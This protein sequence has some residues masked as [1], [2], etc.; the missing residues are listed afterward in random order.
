MDTSIYFNPKEQGILV[1]SNFAEKQ[2]QMDLGIFPMISY[3][4][5]LYSDLQNYTFNSIAFDKIDNNSFQSIKEIFLEYKFDS[6]AFHQTTID[7]HDL[8]IDVNHLIIGDSSKVNLSKKNF[9]NLKEITFLSVKTFKGKILDTL[10]SVE[11]LILWYEN[12]KSN[13]IL[14]MLHNIKEFYIYN[15]SL[16]ELDLTGNPRLERLQLHRCLKLEK[17][18]LNP[19]ARLR[20]VIIESCN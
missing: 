4:K 10:G 20:N 9:E 7:L 1:T 19:S 8:V 2:R 15:G 11:K 16:I 14:A 3:S 18:V 13:S 5:I 12:K 17:V 6:V